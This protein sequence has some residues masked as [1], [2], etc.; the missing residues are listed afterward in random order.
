MQNSLAIVGAGRVGRALGRRF[1]ELG[2]KIGAVVTRKEANAR[3]AVR[4]IGA[5][6]PHAGVSRAILA[7]RGILIATPD[8]EIAAV[9]QDLAR[10][11]GAELAGR[12]VLPPTGPRTSAAFAL[13]KT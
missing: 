5:G 10:G 9:A 11:A 6:R 7:S 8:D 12:A 4:F 13:L 1:R 2:W 3:K